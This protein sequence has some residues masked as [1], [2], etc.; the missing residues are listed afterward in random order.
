MIPAGEALVRDPGHAGDPLNGYHALPPTHAF[1]DPLNC[2]VLPGTGEAY[3][4]CGAA[5][6]VNREG[7]NI[8][9]LVE[10]CSNE[11]GHYK[12]EIPKTCHRLECPICQSGT[13]QRAAEAM[14]NRV[15][16]YRRAVQH[17][18]M[19]LDG[20]MIRSGGRPPRHATMDLSRRETNA[21]CDRTVRALNKRSPGEWKLEDAEALFVEK[22]RAAVRRHLKKLDVEAGAI[23]VHLDR[24]TD[25]GKQ[26]FRKAHP[27]VILASEDDPVSGI[28]LW[29]WIRDQDNWRELIYFAPHAHILVYGSHVVDTQDYY[30]ET[31]TFYKIIRDITPKVNKDHEYLDNRNKVVSYEEAVLSA[32]TG[33]CYYLLSHTP[34]SKGRVSWSPFGGLHSS[35]LSGAYTIK[36]DVKTCPKCDSDIIKAVEDDSGEIVEEVINNRTGEVAVSWKKKKICWWWFKGDPI[37]PGIPPNA[38]GSPRGEVKKPFADYNMK[39]IEDKFGSGWGVVKKRGGGS[40][41]G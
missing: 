20:V 26:L 41:R 31:G 40:V 16:G 32:I 6:K 27:G 36:K 2:R 5:I 17:R 14:A 12:R 30:E 13:L 24:V 3:D 21:V 33:V 28:A 25:R 38:R 18:N 10:M 29:R 7:K 11:P 1:F 19:T 9:H 39:R 35:K 23:V 4:T 37:P 8:G 22:F 15:N 34:V